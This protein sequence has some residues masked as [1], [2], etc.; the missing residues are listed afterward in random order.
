MIIK[1]VTCN[2]DCYIKFSELFLKNNPIVRCNE[3]NKNYILSKNYR[4]IDILT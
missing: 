1:N 4:I 3:C 2:H